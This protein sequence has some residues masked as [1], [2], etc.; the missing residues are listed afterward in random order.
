MIRMYGIPN[1]DTVKKA[2]AHLFQLGVNDLEFVNL[3]TVIPT[4]E[5]ILQWKRAFEGQW[6]VNTK[7]PTY[8]KIK[9]KFEAANDK[10]KIKIL[11]E[12]TSAIKRP[13]LEVHGKIVSVGYNE[14]KYSQAIRLKNKDD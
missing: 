13:I 4:E 12:N 10:A 5:L 8:R 14:T 7:G 3:K 2:K 1:C 11:Q 9:E 6:P